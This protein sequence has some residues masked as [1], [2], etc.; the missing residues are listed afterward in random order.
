[1]SVVLTTISCSETESECIKCHEKHITGMKSHIIYE[2]S[3]MSFLDENGY[4]IYC[5]D[6]FL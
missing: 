6:F 1:M 4:W 3:C 2:S 5:S